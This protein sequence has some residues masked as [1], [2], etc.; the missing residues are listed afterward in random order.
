MAKRCSPRRERC[1]AARGTDPAASPPTVLSERP[2]PV[3]WG[4]RAAGLHRPPSARTGPEPEHAR[5][6]LP[7]GEGQPRAQLQDSTAARGGGEGRRDAGKRLNSFSA[8]RWPPRHSLSP[9]SC[10]PSLC[11][12]PDWGQGRGELRR[13]WG[14][15]NGGLEEGK[16][17]WLG[18]EGREW[19]GGTK[20]RRGR[21]GGLPEGP[22]SLVSFPYTPEVKLPSEEYSYPYFIGESVKR[23]SLQLSGPGLLISVTWSIPNLTKPHTLFLRSRNPGTCKGTQSLVTKLQ[24]PWKLCLELRARPSSSNGRKGL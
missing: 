9:E 23:D 20:A 12:G 2:Q 5:C 10:A 1:A 17:S 4:P 19:W 16:G 13:G 3:H 8:G 15:G 6:G 24:V 7:P 11:G 14:R 21:K 22:L 18:E